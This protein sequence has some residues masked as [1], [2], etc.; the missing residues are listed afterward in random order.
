MNISGDQ[1]D[2]IADIV[3]F[4]QLSDRLATAGQPTIKQYPAIAAAGYQVVINLALTDSPSALADE[5][6]LAAIPN[7]DF[8][9]G[10]GKAG[11]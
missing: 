8:D 3:N 5:S 1:A 7:S 2:N 9:N 11:E 4:L 6:E 10:R